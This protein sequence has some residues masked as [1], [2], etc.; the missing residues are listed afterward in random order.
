MVGCLPPGLQTHAPLQSE[1]P[2]S[3]YMRELTWPTR[4]PEDQ[5]RFARPAGVRSDA[6]QDRMR[7]RHRTPPPVPTTLAAR[8][9][10]PPSPPLLRAA[11]DS[12]TQVLSETERNKLLH[13][14]GGAATAEE[15]GRQWETWA[16]LTAKA[17]ARGEAPPPPPP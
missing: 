15:L 13:P 3:E 5:V 7:G 12:G 9:P 11:A 2:M 1:T 10:S 14:T 16:Q 8:A 17:L 4:Y 6:E